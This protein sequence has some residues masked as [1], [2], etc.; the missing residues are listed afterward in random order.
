MKGPAEAVRPPLRVEDP[1]LTLVEHLTEL[2]SRLIWSLLA[3]GT[4]TVAVYP[5]SGA[6]LSRLAR[7]AGTLYFNAPADAFMTRLRVAVFTGFA[8]ALPVVLAQVWLFTARAMEP[9]WRRAIGRL[10]PLSYL[11]FLCGA[12]LA[13][14][15]VA[16]AAIRFLIA[17]GSDDIRPLLSLGS[18]VSF[19]T[20]LM[21]SFGAVFQLP[22]VLVGLN[23]A[24]MVSRR[25]LADRRRVAYFLIVVGA[26]LLTPGPDVVSQ[27]A[28]ALPAV[29]LFE[30]TLLA[31]A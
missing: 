20:D 24:G 18:Y 1:P 27:A 3:V 16:P 7:P 11:L 31:L 29:A 10:L 23:R 26:A 21:L 4:A 5:W 22:L 8:I 28:L 30:L 19:V 15:V 9:K 17:F 12:A 6:L 2:R 13:F 25:F 14:F